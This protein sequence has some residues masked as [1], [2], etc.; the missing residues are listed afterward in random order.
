MIKG[1]ML[2]KE[3]YISWDLLPSRDAKNYTAHHTFIYIETIM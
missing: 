1:L 3:Y 2:T